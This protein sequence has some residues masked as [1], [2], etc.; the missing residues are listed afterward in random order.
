MP[1]KKT[2]SVASPTGTRVMEVDQHGNPV[3]NGFLHKHFGSKPVV[4]TNWNVRNAQ[5]GSTSPCPVWIDTVVISD[6][7]KGSDKGKTFAPPHPHVLQSSS[8]TSQNVTAIAV[9]K[10]GKEKERQVFKFSL[11]R[12]I[13]GDPP[14]GEMAIATELWL[15]MQ[16][17]DTSK[18][19]IATMAK[20]CIQ[21]PGA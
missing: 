1:F 16:P 14:P 13:T 9:D 12:A 15:S 7:P 11:V 19:E 5:P 6:T 10:N 4:T 21:E 3:T 18:P 17:I 8:S 2:D 20:R